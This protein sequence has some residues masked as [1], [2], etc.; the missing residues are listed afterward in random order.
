[1]TQLTDREALVAEIRD[2]LAAA[3]DVDTGL[4]LVLDRTLAGFNC[5]VGTIHVLPT[6]SNVM[7][8]RAHTGVPAPLVEKVRE[9]PIG[10]GMA[11]LAAERRRPVQVCNLQTDDS[12]AVKPG[13]KETAMAGSIAVP[14]L[15]GDEL[16]GVLGIAKPTA[17]DFTPEEVDA[18]MAIGSVVGKAAG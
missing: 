6:G 14:M 17:Y 4:Q 10:K 3:P 13:A 12:G 5:V 11:G 7:V 8:L 1:M 9:V 16:R 18:L 2:G 15:V